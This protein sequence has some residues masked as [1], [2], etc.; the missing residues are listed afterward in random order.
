M[1]LAGPS[2][3]KPLKD[4][5]SFL[6]PEIEHTLEQQ[7]EHLHTPIEVEMADDGEGGHHAEKLEFPLDLG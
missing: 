6:L 2:I 7:R 1:G 3:S 4:R 5:D